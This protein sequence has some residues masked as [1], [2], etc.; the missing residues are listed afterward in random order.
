MDIKFISIYNIF[1]S[2]NFFISAFSLFSIFKLLIIFI[3]FFKQTENTTK[4][5]LIYKHWTSAMNILFS[6]YN[7][8]KNIKIE[9]FYYKVT[10]APMIFFYILLYKII[11]CKQKLFELFYFSVN[12]IKKSRAIGD[13][14]KHHHI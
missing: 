6:F 4:F 8:H 1:S 10:F 11:L 13:D 12:Y 2:D 7:L 14:L 3:L 9:Q 5:F